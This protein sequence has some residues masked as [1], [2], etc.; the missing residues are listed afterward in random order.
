[1]R[2]QGNW[3]NESKAGFGESDHKA[4][5]LPEEKTR[6]PWM[7]DELLK[8]ENSFRNELKSCAITLDLICDKVKEK[9]KL[10]GESKIS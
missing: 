3:D 6:A 1:M 2:N 7:A 8:I 10:Q 4:K 9:D 5:E